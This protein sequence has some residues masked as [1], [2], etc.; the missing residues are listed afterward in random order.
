MAKKTA[1]VSTDPVVLIQTLIEKA[2]PET[3]EGCT[4]LITDL[5][6]A[7]RRLVVSS[8]EALKSGATDRAQLV[9]ELDRVREH[10]AEIQT[11]LQAEVSASEILHVTIAKLEEELSQLRSAA[12]QSAPVSVLALPVESGTHRVVRPVRH[13]GKTYRPGDPIKLTSEHA[14][15]LHATGV[16]HVEDND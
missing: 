6:G 7:L 2:A 14:T 8:T 4:I 5:Q 13:N 10:A 9:V 1:D 16:I 15:R 11:R 3:L 12:I